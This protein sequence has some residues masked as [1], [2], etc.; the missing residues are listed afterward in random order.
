MEG[1]SQHPL[2][3][4]CRLVL[5]GMV[6]LGVY[7]LMALRFN[8]SMALVCMTTD[9]TIHNMTNTSMIVNQCQDLDEGREL[10]NKTKEIEEMLNLGVDGIFTNY[11]CQTLNF[12]LQKR[13]Y[14]QYQQV[15]RK[16]HRGKKK[17]NANSQ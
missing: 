15:R 11:P 7:H 2:I 9:P 12:L 4:S 1:S 17:D 5:T 14:Q 3:G 16:Q 13:H 6:F 10:V 8:L